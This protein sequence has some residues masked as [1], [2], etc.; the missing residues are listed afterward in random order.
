MKLLTKRRSAAVLLSAVLATGLV[1]CADD[2]KTSEEESEKPVAADGPQ[3][4]RISDAEEL[5]LTGSDIGKGF[6]SQP[7]IPDLESD[8]NGCLG[9]FDQAQTNQQF[10]VESQFVEDGVTVTSQVSTYSTVG[11]P[12]GDILRFR[13][14]LRSCKQFTQTRSGADY[15]VELIFNETITNPDA[16]DQLN[17][18]GSGSITENGVT[19]DLSYRYTLTRIE[20]N[21][22]GIQIASVGPNPDELSE[23]IRLNDL[24]VERLGEMAGLP[25]EESEDAD[26]GE[27]PSEDSTESEDSEDTA[28][29]REPLDAGFYR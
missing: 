5:L 20:N 16:Q 8:T 19:Q 10:E 27:E 2:A 18:L 24:L 28:D 3:I 14:A 21:I 23:L 25:G 6:E 26:P 4:L 1:G 7:D 15:D 29:A 9:I 11:A 12:K 22:V 13:K 17:V